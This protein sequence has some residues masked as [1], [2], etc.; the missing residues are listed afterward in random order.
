MWWW[1]VA[2]WALT[3]TYSVQDICQ[4]FPLAGLQAWLGK[5][6]DRSIG[7]GISISTLNTQGVSQY[8]FC[9][10]RTAKVRP[11]VNRT[12]LCSK[13]S[14]DVPSS[15]QRA[16]HQFRPAHFISLFQKFPKQ[17]ALHYQSKWFL[18]YKWCVEKAV[19]L[20]TN[21]RCFT[22]AWKHINNRE[23]ET[24][25]ASATIRHTFGYISETTTTTTT[26]KKR[27]K[28]GEKTLHT[29]NNGITKHSVRSSLDETSA[30]WS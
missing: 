11:V 4:S 15:H 1:S 28:K 12:G 13:P 16:E 7:F 26:K 22:V 9:M 2:I 10:G 8:Q 24:C 6:A 30:W 17:P 5:R 21:S 20:K 25:Y 18:Q 3:I 19:E 14:Q 27:K 23:E 29:P